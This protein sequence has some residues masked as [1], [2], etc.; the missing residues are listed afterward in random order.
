M[1]Y[2]Q[3]VINKTTFLKKVKPYFPKAEIYKKNE[4]IIEPQKNIYFR[5]DNINTTL[6]LSCK[7]LEWVSRP[8]YKGL[9]NYWHSYFK[10]GLNSYFA[11]D[12]SNDDIEKIYTHLGNGV[13]RSLCEIFVKNNF[14]LTL[15]SRTK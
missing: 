3:L 5:I 8:S 7:M 14:D 15:L 6:G 4:L 1:F 11:M 10:R 13:N 2:E 12:W 9:N